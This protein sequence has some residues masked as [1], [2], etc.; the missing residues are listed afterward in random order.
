M[1]PCGDNGVTTLS[2]RP[3]RTP[4][5]YRLRSVNEREVQWCLMT[6]GTTVDDLLDELVNRPGWHRRA[7]CRGMG[8][9]D[10]FPARGEKTDAAKAVCAGCE[11]TA[12]CLE[13][14][15]TNGDRH[16]VWGGISERGRRVL[17]RGAA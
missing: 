3:I 13:D 11:V 5:P 15:M 12:Q 9:D 16:G 7:A 14:A 8:T 1:D 2:I 6:P 17:R 4:Q 10:F